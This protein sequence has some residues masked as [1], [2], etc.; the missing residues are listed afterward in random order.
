MFPRLESLESWSL[1]D[2]AKPIDLCQEHS[3]FLLQQPDLV[4]PAESAMATGLRAAIVEH[5]ALQAE[6]EKQLQ[7][8]KEKCQ[9]AQ[10]QLEGE[11][12]RMQQQQA[13]VVATLTQL[14]SRVDAEQASCKN[15]L[16]KIYSM[17]VSSMNLDQAHVLCVKLTEMELPFLTFEEHGIDGAALTTMGERDFEQL[18]GIEPIGLRHRL[19]HCIRQ[20][21]HVAAPE[22]LTADFEAAEEKL[23]EWLAEQADISESHRQLLSHAR[24]DMITCQHV[25]VSELGMAGI[26]FAARKPLLMLL[27]HPG[28][29]VTTTVRDGQATV[30]NWHPEVQQT[31]LRQVLQENQAL[32]ERLCQQ[33]RGHEAT[34]P[35]EYLCPITCEVMEDPVIAED[36]QTYE[37]EAIATWVAADG[38]SPMTR[39]S[40]PNRFIPNRIVKGLIEKWKEAPANA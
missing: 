7:N 36:G 35:D 16:Q 8:V 14:Q 33:Q 18:F 28:L 25:T 12:L 20:A 37:R 30:V 15:A 23:V 31:V 5:T 32:A 9:Q 38:T 34:V 2:R 3:A 19:V 29:E 6:L 21:A 26:P 10:V 27:H 11:V 22:L 24:F 1:S 39:Q 17:P 4:Q 13:E 40:M